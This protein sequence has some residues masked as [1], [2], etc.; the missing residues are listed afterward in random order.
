MWAVR[1]D[2]D[3][4]SGGILPQPQLAPGAGKFQRSFKEHLM[5]LRDASRSAL[6]SPRVRQ[7]AHARTEAGAPFDVCRTRQGVPP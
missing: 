6:S 3:A 7:S 1:D 4:L 2:S 5:P